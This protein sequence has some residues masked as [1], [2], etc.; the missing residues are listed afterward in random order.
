MGGG[1]Q[2]LPFYTP[3][4]GLSQKGTAEILYAHYKAAG[5]TGQVFGRALMPSLCTA[6]AT[7]AILLMMMKSCP[8]S[9]VMQCT[10]PSKPPNHLPS[11]LLLPHWR[12]FSINIVLYVTYMSRLNHYPGLVEVLAKYLARSIQFQ[13]SQR[14]FNTKTDPAQPSYPMLLIVVWNLHAREALG[15]AN[16]NWFQLLK[17]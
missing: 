10:P 14:W 3:C 7:S 8:N 11:S 6:V 4:A 17:Q 9:R 5:F 15:N 12:G 2:I 13:T 1:G 16:K